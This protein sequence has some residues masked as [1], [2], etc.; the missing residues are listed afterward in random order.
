[1]Q[2]CYRQIQQALMLAEQRQGIEML[3]EAFF[4]HFFATY[5]ETREYFRDTDIRK[6]G[7][8]K[9]RIVSSFLLD[10]VRHPDF[11]EVELTDEVRRH[12][13]YGLKDKAYYFALIDA[14]EQSVREALQQ[15]WEGEMAESW[16][17]VTLAMKGV[18]GQASAFV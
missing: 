5:P 15:D 1:M 4:G 2:S 16:H 10:I 14:L 18:I 3:S 13:A 17:D 12:L 6:F 7:P 11:A 8:E 9:F